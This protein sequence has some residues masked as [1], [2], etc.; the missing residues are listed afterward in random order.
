ML[1][2]DLSVLWPRNGEELTTL[3]QVGIEEINKFF[4][5]SSRHQFGSD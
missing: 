5:H 1:H 3:C 2:F 4:L